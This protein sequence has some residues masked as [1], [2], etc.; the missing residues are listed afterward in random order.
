MT[1]NLELLR[2]FMAVVDAGG[3]KKAEQQINRPQS[4]ISRHIQKLEVDLGKLLIERDNS[5]VRLTEHGRCYFPFAKR[6]L[7]LDNDSRSA[8][9]EKSKTMRVRLGIPGE[10]CQTERETEFAQFLRKYSE[11]NDFQL[12]VFSSQS[13]ELTNR[14]LDG[15]LDL[16]IVK[17]CLY[18]PGGYFYWQE[19]LQWVAK[20]R[21]NLQ[22]ERPVPMIC[23]S[24]GCAYRA[25]AIKTLER[26]QLPWRIVYES[27]SWPAVKASI[28]NGLGIALLANT[29]DLVGFEFLT[30]S[31]GFPSVPPSYFVIRCRQ[32]PP[33]GPVAALAD[34]LVE[35]VPRYRPVHN[36]DR[37]AAALTA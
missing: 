10:F 20:A 12:E 4:T 37:A 27:Q 9:T 15:K 3:F 32:T 33:S 17:E 36:L 13:Q 8:L 21:A 1:L 16:A 24:D 7:E 34:K 23:F 25:K 14:L 18:T 30:E 5:T 28:E 2:S 22:H 35:I 11:K 29:R 6:I 26:A 19:H 31:Q